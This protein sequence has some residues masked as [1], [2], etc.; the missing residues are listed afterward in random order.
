MAFCICSLVPERLCC[1]RKSNR[2]SQPQ[3]LNTP[4]TRHR[5]ISNCPSAW[6]QQLNHQ[7][8]HLAPPATLSHMRL[9]RTI[10]SIQHLPYLDNQPTN[11]TTH[12]RNHLFIQR[13]FGWWSA[14]VHIVVVVLIFTASD[15][16][17][18]IVRDD[19][20]DKIDNGL[21]WVFYFMSFRWAKQHEMVA[22]MMRCFSVSYIWFVLLMLCDS[23]LK[24]LIKKK[25][26][27][28]AF[29]VKYWF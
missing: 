12:N 20:R 15:A 9:S 18:V 2:F 10:L 25:S 16:H 11:P 24:C 14:M 29:F 6:E 1:S 26:F 7:H 21:D 19:L 3:Q 17:T 27:Y 22:M 5:P 13:G 23:I 4:H 8:H 28:Y